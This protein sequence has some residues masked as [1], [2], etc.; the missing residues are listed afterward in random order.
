[1]AKSLLIGLGGTGSRIVNSVVKEL[2]ENKIEINNGEI[3]CAVLDTNVNDNKSIND[4]GTG[5][6]VI[7]TSTSQTVEQYFVK[8]KHLGIED[9][10]PS[11]P[12]LKK[13]DMKDGASELRVKSRIAFMDCVESGNLEKQL[14]PIINRA[15]EK[16]P[17]AK[18]RIMIVSSLAGGTG[19]GMFIQ[20]ALWLRQF[21]GNIPITIRGIFVLPDIF[22]NT[23]DNIRSN[24]KKKE[25]HYANTYAAIRELNTITAVLK[26]KKF[27]LSEK[28]TLD[29]LFNSEK[30]LGTGKPVYDLAFFID[31]EDSNKHSLGSSGEYEQMIAQLVYMQLYSPMK[32]DMYSEEDN[33]FINELTNVEPLYGSCGAAKAVYP[34]QSVKEYC[35]LR[36]VQDSIATG[37]GRID[38]EIEARREEK[39]Q[40][41]RD[42]IFSN[43][44]ID[45]ATTYMHLF[46][47]AISVNAEKA[48]RDRFFL[49][50]KNDIKN[51][52][53]A[54]E[55][56]VANDS[57]EDETQTTNDNSDKTISAID[58]DTDSSD[59][60]GTDKVEDFLTIISFEKINPCVSKNN[61]LKEILIGDKDSYIAN[62]FSI[63][64]LRDKAD[65]DMKCLKDAVAAFETRVKK[66][67]DDIVDSI[68]PYNMGK[69]NVTDKCTIYGLLTKPDELGNQRFIHPLAAR[70]VLYKLS[71]L[72]K[73]SVRRLKP[74]REK[75]IKFS[76]GDAT[77]DNERTKDKE[78]T[79]Q[80]YLNSKK[81]FQFEGSFLTYYKEKY[82]SF[83][84]TK[85][86]QAKK[87][88]TD[89]LLKAV[90]IGLV[91]RVDKLIKKF[92]SFF[93]N[94]DEIQRELN[95]SLEA[96]IAETERDSGKIT[97][98]LGDR[99]SKEG[100]YQSLS[101]SSDDSD[102]RINKSIIDSIYGSC[103]AEQR[104]SIEF[105][106]KY[107]KIS[108]VLSF[109]K[110]A[111]ELYAKKIENDEDNLK[112]IDLDIYTAFGRESE[113]K[114]KNSAKSYSDIFN[115]K[116]NMLKQK[117]ALFL[118]YKERPASNENGTKDIIPATF[119]GF[120]PSI[121]SDETKDA[122]NS[123][124]V[125]LGL[126]AD[127]AYP[128]NE[129]CCYKAVYGVRAEDIVKLQETDDG[130]CYYR[131]YNAIIKDMVKAANTSLGSEAYARTPH[132]DKTWHSLLPYITNEKR[133]AEKNAFYHAFWLAI[134]YGVIF[135]DK[136]GKLRLRREIRDAS[137]T[138][139]DKIKPI[140]Y[141]NLTLKATDVHELITVLKTDMFFMD[142]DIP[143][144]E[145]K[146]Q[147]ELDSMSTYVGTEVLQGLM[148][149]S[150][151]LN[152]ID[153]AS[154]Y[155]VSSDYDVDV[156]TGLKS[157]LERIAKELAERYYREREG[158]S[159][160][161]SQFRICKMIYDSSTRSQGKDKIFASWL[162][163]FRTY[164]L[165]KEKF[166]DS[167]NGD[168]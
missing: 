27:K 132:L 125:N 51:D 163:M 77:F 66:F 114:D 49:T 105:N 83:I 112:Y 149:K 12:A 68:F 126:Q 26:S 167:T 3:C 44:K 74:N 7:P 23:L 110:E 148:K 14:R 72:L 50:I 154:R 90:Y 99:E 35:I 127:E 65:S 64:Q 31:Y 17:G 160:E 57:P 6:P 162:R 13:A 121:D 71:K 156:A 155:N 62:K 168:S 103:C 29:K 20:V 16:D 115:D 8:Y 137:G 92:E 159:L 61:G 43:E 93:R 21:F 70:Y 166:T 165:D 134:A 48:G 151:E 124:G 142:F 133:E 143:E 82:Y 157:G 139:N 46:E 36:A 164:K 32:D 104:P 100:I 146:Y 52:V 69:V 96:N 22:V 129:L 41:E 116:A 118:D 130:N 56:D 9:W 40:L 97:Y 136:D 28:I 140:R 108:L 161:K 34:T 88:E 120:N 73:D 109:I 80:D 19:S 4:S 78:A 2:H 63:S 147:K 42:G 1:M 53:E 37:W 123:L 119:W 111:R 113:I 33:L 45:T 59:V 150:N 85:Y 30:D 79:P 39:R 94:I 81:R 152:P 98:V 135:A 95:K 91:S 75:T 87:Y 145:E 122:L 54:D 106:T 102:A 153:V 67:A 84:N 101:F 58:I 86:A 141:N 15:I 138:V 60:E 18:F 89:I 5:V 107:K 47:Q 10:C 11:A 24:A 25:R 128:K 117:A 158:D 131:Y 76:V 144:L 38:S 55:T